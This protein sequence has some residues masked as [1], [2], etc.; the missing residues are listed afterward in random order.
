MLEHSENLIQLPK[1]GKAEWL[2]LF[3]PDS[4]WKE[5]SLHDLQSNIISKRNLKYLGKRVTLLR[6][7][8]EL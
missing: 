6:Q 1:R 7:E 5:S 3:E 8:F 4:Y 2:P